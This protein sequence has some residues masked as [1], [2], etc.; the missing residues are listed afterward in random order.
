M[1]QKETELYL[2]VKQFLEKQGFLVKGEVR[3]CDLTAVR[4]DE[5]VVVELKRKFNLTLV[6]Q[7]VE[8]QK[9]TD[10]V[11]LAVEAPKKRQ[12]GGHEW[13]EVQGLCRRLG[14]G[15]LT[16]N[17]A[18]QNPRVEVVVEPGPYLPRK[19]ARK[20]TL[21]LREFDR[22]SGDYNVGGSTRSPIVTGYREEALRIARHLKVHGTASPKQIRDALGSPGVSG[23]LQK[24]FYGWY[25]RVQRGIYRLTAKGET[26][27]QQ[28]AAVLAGDQKEE[29]TEP[30]MRDG[31]GDQDMLACGTI[32]VPQ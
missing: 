18:R 28:Y 26:A 12:S 4:G 25:E 5:L 7:G 24:N 30:C 14:L 17:F 20:R 1:A 10:G 3:G 11:Y 27:L 23:I 16:V 13:N 32:N 15:L 19:S 9:V 29:H 8:R 21:L 6:L 31:E 22:R 2:P